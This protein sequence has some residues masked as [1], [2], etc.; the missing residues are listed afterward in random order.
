[1]NSNPEPLFPVP[2]WSSDGPA[3]TNPPQVS[4]VGIPPRNPPRRP[5]GRLV[6]L[7]VVGLLVIGASALTLIRLAGSGE[8]GSRYPI[9]HS[10][11]VPT[12]GSSTTAAPAPVAADPEA[13][14]FD[15][16]RAQAAADRADVLGRVVERWVPQVSSKQVGLVA[17][18]QTWNNSA[19]LH[20]HMALRLRYPDARLLWTGDWSTFTLRDW[21]VTVIGTT[22]PTAGSANNWCMAQGFDRDHC[23]AKLISTTH[24]IEGSTVQWN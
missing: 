8:E 16:L 19:I 13:A 2:G 22:F 23:F 11:G 21:W 4:P 1:M 3:P 17:E 9:S 10:N 7:A 15:T 20:E 5:L 14:A 6:A 18:G 24:P 12:R